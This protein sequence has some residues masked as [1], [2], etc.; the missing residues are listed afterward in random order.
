MEDGYYDE[1]D[2]RF[3]AIRH[4][5]LGEIRRVRW[6]EHI[7]D[8]HIHEIHMPKDGDQCLWKWGCGQWST[9]VF[10]SLKCRIGAELY[11]FLFRFPEIIDI[12]DDIDM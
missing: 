4:R 8:D 5:V 12:M 10:C 2:A 3:M 6:I 9:P 1:D 7:N 11:E